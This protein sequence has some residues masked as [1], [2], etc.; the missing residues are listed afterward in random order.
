MKKLLSVYMVY[1]NQTVTKQTQRYQMMGIADVK[2]FQKTQFPD[3][4]G[5]SA[6]V[7]YDDKHIAK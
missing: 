6:F 1:F 7:D 3:I 5:M 4:M 2:N